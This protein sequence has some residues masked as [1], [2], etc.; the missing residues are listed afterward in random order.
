MTGRFASMSQANVG[1]LIRECGGHLTRTLSLR[2]R[3]LVV[4]QGGLPLEQDGQPS[5][6]L[7]T[8]RRLISA[9]CNLEI[10]T[11]EA[12]VE[13]L[14]LVQETQG[15]RRRCTIVEL[16][17]ILKLPGARIRTWLKQGLIEP[18]EIVNRVALFDFHQV[19]AAR[20]LCDL[21][22]SGLPSA[23]IRRGLEQLKRLL[24]EAE[25]PLLQVSALDSTSRLLIRLDN[26]QL[27]EPSGQ[28]HLDFEEE[29]DEAD[30]VLSFIAVARKVDDLFEDAVAL[31]SLGRFQDAAET[32]QQALR[33]DPHDPVLH[34]N[35]GNVLIRLDQTTAAA[36][37]FRQALRLD[38]GYVE[39]W[40]NLG[41]MQFELGQVDEAIA[42]FQRAL[43]VVPSYADACFNLAMALTRQGRLADARRSW[44]T[45]LKLDPNSSFADT[46][47]QHL[48]DVER[49]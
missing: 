33:Q 34:F 30:E 7:E 35:L 45:Y 12:F 26:G 6:Q 15:I 47:R 36:V 29:R 14:G 32:Y 48:Q 44:Q 13:R 38:P 21:V 43:S 24:P 20:T 39:A 17:R 42:S 19:A 1:E 8:A 41:S 49:A 2:T 37:Q 22:E 5:S 31:E 27:A 4:G 18:A 40:N 10:V 25:S 9:G 11:E 23:E 46:A 28:L 16:A 3:L